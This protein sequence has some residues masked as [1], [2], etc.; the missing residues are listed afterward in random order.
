MTWKQNL[1]HEPGD[2]I[3]N[4]IGNT[5]SLDKSYVVGICPIAS[6]PRTIILQAKLCKVHLFGLDFLVA[7][8]MA[9][10]DC[11]LANAS[12]CNYVSPEEQS[13]LIELDILEFEETDCR[14]PQT[15]VITSQLFLD[16]NRSQLLLLKQS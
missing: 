4:A 2:I 16:W 9:I 11:D 8:V 12:R 14:A 5:D 10:W 13:N 6:N 15:S 7:A 3:G 1:N